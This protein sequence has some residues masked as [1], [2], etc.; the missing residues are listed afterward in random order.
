MVQL[1]QAKAKFRTR[2]INLAA[3]SYDNEAILKEFGARF[4]IEF[5]LLSDPRSEVIRRF[6]VLDPD[7]GP[8]NLPEYAKK[9]M[10]YPGFIYV[11]RNGVVR[12]KFFGGPY[13]DRYT[14][15]NTLGKLFPELLEGPGP[16]VKTSHLRATPGQSDREAT[17]GSRVTLTVEVELPRGM[18]VYAP[19]AK[20]Y[21]PVQLFIAPADA[22]R[23][24]ESKYP[25]PEVMFLRAIKEKVPVY[26]GRFRL[27][28]DVLI[29]PTRTLQ[30]S[31]KALGGGR[32]NGVVLKLT[33]RLK[34][35]ACGPTTCYLPAEVPLNWEVRVHAPDDKR[36]SEVVQ[37]KPQ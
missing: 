23:P 4:R 24:K 30:E 14:A 19:G 17:L 25:R 5:P 8:N 2:G 28:Q 7:N 6:D 13:F 31:L 22:A 27:T 26:R 12:D 3:V 1:Q 33:G 34:Y 16:P 29:A 37:D 32:E 35:Q 9:D 20:N 11:D 15:N 18:H 36:A 21:L 10:A